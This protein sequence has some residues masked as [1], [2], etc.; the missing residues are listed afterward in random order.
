MRVEEKCVFLRGE[1]V[2][3][4]NR[5]GENTDGE[6]RERGLRGSEWEI[7]VYQRRRKWKLV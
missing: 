1:C 2:R 3:G 7:N 4:E 6:C 5:D